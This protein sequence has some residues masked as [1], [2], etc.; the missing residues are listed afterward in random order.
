MSTDTVILAMLDD[1]DTL[2]YYDEDIGGPTVE[3]AVYWGFIDVDETEKIITV[4]L[5]YVIYNSSPGNDR[6]V[7]LSGSVGGRLHEFD[8]K[9][10]GDSERQAKWVL[11]EARKMLSRKRLGRSLIKR[12]DDNMQVRRDDTYSRPGGEPLF[13]GVDRYAVAT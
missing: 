11:D 10:V 12:S 2:T 3:N 4:P 13:Y 1:S 6:N 7:R 8:L 5:P 9:G